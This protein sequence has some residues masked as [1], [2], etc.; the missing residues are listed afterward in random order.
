MFMV[1]L[2][3]VAE[4]FAKS[5]GP[6]TWTRHGDVDLW[7]RGDDIEITLKMHG[8]DGKGWS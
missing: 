2:K 8:L 4:D 3:E 5:F 6:L 1:G 7:G